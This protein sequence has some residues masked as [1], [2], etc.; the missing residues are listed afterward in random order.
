MG[1]YLQTFICRYCDAHL[2][3]DY[4]SC[5]IKVELEQGLCMLPM[6]EELFNQINNH[7]NS[8][9]IDTFEC[10]TEKI[11]SKVLV[12]AKN[13]MFAYV[14]AEYH[15]GE[16]GQSGII[17][18]K[19]VRQQMFSSGQNV[20]NDV[21]KHFGTKRTNGLDEFDSLGQGRYRNTVNWISM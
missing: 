17:W 21:L 13:I 19:G 8:G 3:T 7:S 2:I 12:T 14:E 20:I 1:Y 15:G 18:N 4:F 10:L 9:Y 16:G 11:E 6:T 5:A